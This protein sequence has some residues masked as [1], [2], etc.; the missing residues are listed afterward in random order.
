MAEC[1]NKVKIGPRRGKL[2][3]ENSALPPNLLT[4]HNQPFTSRLR[5][6]S[7]EAG[8]LERQFFVC[9]WLLWKLSR[10]ILV[11]LLLILLSSCGS[12]VHG[13]VALASV[14]VVSW[15]PLLPVELTWSSGRGVWNC[16]LQVLCSLLLESGW[17]S[18]KKSNPGP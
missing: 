2:L 15:G 6:L 1:A 10:R 3:R 9:S 11:R 17:L 7:T 12:R 18:V 13:C 4:L 16:G 14:P 8:T 5:R